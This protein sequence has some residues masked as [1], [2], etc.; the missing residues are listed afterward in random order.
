VRAYAPLTRDDAVAKLLRETRTTAVTPVPAAMED[1]SPQRPPG[2]PATSEADRKAFQRQQVR[3]GLELRGW[4]VQEMLVTPSPLT[5]RMTLFWHNHFVSSQQKV[6]VARLMYRQNA[7]LR[8][9]ALGNFGTLLH[10]PPRATRRWSYIW[11]ARR[12][13]RVRRTRTS[14]AR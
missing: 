1:P 5:E 4:W 8:S 2:G 9:Q 13:A 12:T 11:T 6:R 10:A 14:P 3:E 7:L